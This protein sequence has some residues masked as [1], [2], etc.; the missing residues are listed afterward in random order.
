MAQGCDPEEGPSTTSRC[1][2]SRG[3]GPGAAGHVARQEKEL[4]LCSTQRSGRGGSL[5]AHISTPWSILWPHLH[6]L[7]GL[8]SCPVSTPQVS[9]PACIFTHTPFTLKPCSTPWSTV[10]PHLRPLVYTRTLS[11][12]LA[13]ST[14]QP[15]ST[16]G[17]HSCPP[18]ST[19]WST[20]ETW[21][22]SPTPSLHSCSVSPL[23]GQSTLQP[24]L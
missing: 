19:P 4:V 7:Q 15:W 14:L 16:P 6:A 13:W 23:L 12:L 20:L 5:H 11:P 21:L 18:V 1:W 8:Q 3:G 2:T 9:T 22:C 17:L 24:Y 10:Q